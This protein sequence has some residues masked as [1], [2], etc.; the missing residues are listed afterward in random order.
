LVFNGSARYCLSDLT[1]SVL[2]FLFPQLEASSEARAA[3]E[4]QLERLTREK[5][6]TLRQSRVPL[7]ALFTPIPT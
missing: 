3:L 1:H 2:F 4:N 5:V 6:D 7:V